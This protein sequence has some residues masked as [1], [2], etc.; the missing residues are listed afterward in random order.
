MRR[1]SFI[2]SIITDKPG[3]ISTM[4]AAARAASVASETAIPQSAFFNAGAS[5]TPSPVMPTMWPSLCKTSTM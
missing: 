4:A 3:V 2:A 1:L 5:F